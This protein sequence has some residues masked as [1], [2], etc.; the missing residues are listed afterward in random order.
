MMAAE[1]QKPNS[2]R[3]RE[4]RESARESLLQGLYSPAPIYAELERVKLADSLALFVERRGGDEPLVRQVLAGKS[5]QARTAE[6]VQGTRLGDVAVRKQIAAGGQA[7]IEA[8]DDPLIQLA[9][10]LE[11]E[12]R[13]IREVFDELEEIERQAYSQ[14][15]TATYAVKG[16]GTYPDAT[17]TLRLAFGVVAGYEKHGQTVP[18]WTTLG[19]TFDHEQKHGGK[20]PWELPAWWRAAKDKLNPTRPSISSAR[21]TSSAAT[22]AAR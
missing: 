5:P 2:E 10:Q 9:R 1:D 15:T 19:G 12:S 17:F 16:T 11:P 7:A 21:R 8:S 20:E 14:I 22:R 6:L 18:P 4:Y 13:R 3:L